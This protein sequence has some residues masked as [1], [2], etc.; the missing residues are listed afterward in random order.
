MSSS[1]CA[2]AATAP[3]AT[4]PETGLAVTGSAVACCTAGADGGS[5]SAAVPDGV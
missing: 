3:A 1:M 5:A 4:S 2:A